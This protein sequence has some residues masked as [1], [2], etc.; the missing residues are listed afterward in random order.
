MPSFSREI[1]PF[2]TQILDFSSCKSTKSKVWA[3]C[4]PDVLGLLFSR[5]AGDGFK[6]IFGNVWLYRGIGCLVCWEQPEVRDLWNCLGW[7]KTFKIMEFNPEKV[8][9]KGKVFQILTQ[10]VFPD[11]FS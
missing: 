3:V 10:V 6:G 7:K 2:P 1:F 8:G 11:G 9:R 5:G 4:E